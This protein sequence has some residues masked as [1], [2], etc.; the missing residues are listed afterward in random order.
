MFFY[1]PNWREEELKIREEDIHS[2]HICLCRNKES[3]ISSEIPKF[4]HFWDLDKVSW[5]ERCPD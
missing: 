1:V 5:L 2:C 4:R 3:T